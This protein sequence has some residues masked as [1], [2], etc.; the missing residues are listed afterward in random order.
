T[1][2]AP[3][4][5]V[6]RGRSGDGWHKNQA[7]F[8]S[9]SKLSDQDSLTVQGDMYHSVAGN[10]HLYP[11]L[12]APYLLVSRDEMFESGGNVLGRWTRNIS[13]E[14]STATQF[15]LDNTQHKTG[16]VAYNATTADFDFQH[17]WTGWERNE[18]IWGAGYRWITDHDGP[19]S[20]FSLTPAERSY[21]VSNAFLQ[22][23]YTLHPNDLFLILGSKFEHNAYSGYEIEPSAKLSWLISDSQM[24]WSSV[25]RAVHTPGRYTADGQLTYAVIPPGALPVSITN[26]GNPNL[27]SEDLTAYEIGYR[28]QPTKS[29]SFDIATFYNDYTNLFFSKFGTGQ[30]LAGPYFFQPL[31]IFND[32]SARSMG[33]EISTKADI[34]KSWQVSG[35]YSYIDLRF[36][37]KGDPGVSY[38]NNPKNQFNVRS[39]YLFPY[40]I[41]MTNSLYYVESLAQANI[42]GYYRF[43]TKLSYEIIKGVEASLVGQNLLQPQHKEFSAFLFQTPVEVGRS[44]YGNI[45]WKF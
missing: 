36:G 8:R 34:T 11:S 28:V 23:K 1:D 16:Y 27:Q 19:S 2:D 12:A 21:S 44:V 17:T 4:F 9:D 35:S 41:E 32:N 39:T 15:Y 40:N 20:L 33:F 22:D 6:G 10:T 3:E 7:G 30:V 29:L 37:N 43:D 45:T 14:S 5:N 25:S 38:A 24:A 26:V 18:I 31:S 42:P 13:P